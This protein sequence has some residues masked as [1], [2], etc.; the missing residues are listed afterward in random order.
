MNLGGKL[1]VVSGSSAGIGAATAKLMAARGAEVV[2]LA[3]GVE[4]LERVG[5]EIEAAGGRARHWSVDLGDSEAV[6][7]VAAEILDQ[8]GVPDVLVN[9]AGIGRWLFI[10]ETLSEEARAIMSVPYH[11]AFDLSKAFV[12]GMVSRGSGNIC[13][14]NGPGAFFP[15]PSS[16][17]Y[18]SARWA[19]RGFSEAMR[20]DLRG[21]GV[22]VTGVY[23]A[24]V[25]SDYWDHNPG[26]ED[27]IPWVD[28]LVPTMSPE[29]AA[30]MV[31]RAVERERREVFAPLQYRLFHLT[32]RLLPRPVQ[33]LVAVS[34]AKRSAMGPPA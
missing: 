6:A 17:A 21:T 25:S 11:A 1:A 10:E 16:V 14:V 12:P 9:N 24:R 29:R 15:W 27:R 20:V 13:N 34:G 30:E 22:T 32:G 31:T 5:G 3:R 26:T 23:M 8:A 7:T 19:L 4:G 18:A 2:L 33:W 28:R